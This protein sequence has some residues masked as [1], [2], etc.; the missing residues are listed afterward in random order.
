[1]SVALSIKNITKR[2]GDFTA[3]D[4]VSFDVEEGELVTVLGLNGAGKTTLVKTLCTLLSPSG[5]D[6]L[7]LGK[8]LVKEK[9]AVKELIA[10]SPQE[11]AVAPNLTV[12]ENLT[13]TAQ[14]F[15]CTKA[16]SVRRAKEQCKRFSLGEVWKK[17]AGKL[18][19]GYQRR[20]SIAMALVCQ[21]KILF[22][23]EPTLGVD[24]LSR[25][26]LWRE[27]ELLKG[28]MTVVM[29][30]HYMEEAESLSEKLAVMDKGKLLFF[31]G[32]EELKNLTGKPN[33]EEA[34]VSIVQK[35]VER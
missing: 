29:T 30:T 22:L 24:V 11:T 15:G 5:G 23:D 17:R 4:G 9:S 31:G 7:V 32:V 2:Y 6:A 3:V 10:V 18:S 25:R 28:K 13:L 12:E 21:P 35:E 19:G 34:F 1:M 33:V 16:E 26:E 20:L 14:M 8:S 27:V